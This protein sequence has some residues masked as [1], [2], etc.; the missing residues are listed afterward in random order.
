MSLI[1]RKGA[2]AS[3]AGFGVRG[4]KWL[5]ICTCLF[6]EAGTRVQP[7]QPAGDQVAQILEDSEFCCFR[8]GRDTLGSSSPFLGVYRV[9]GASRAVSWLILTTVLWVDTIITFLQMKKLSPRKVMSP[10]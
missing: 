5:L 1:V 8:A 3:S 4:R 10:A 2:V 7:R 9:P 6:R